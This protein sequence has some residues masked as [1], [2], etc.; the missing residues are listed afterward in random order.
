ML[1]ALRHRNFRLFFYGQSISL[2]GT[3]MQNIALSWLVYRM[4]DSVFLLGIVGFS[5]QIAGFV[6]TPFAGVIADRHHRQKLLI[7]TQFAAMLQA[8]VLTILVAT[9]QIQVWHIILL[10]LLMGAIN[11]FDLPVRQA[12]ISDMIDDREDLSNAIAINSSMVNGARLIGPSIGGILIAMV[13]EV[14]CFAINA[15]SYIAV[16]ISLYN[17]QVAKK[18]ESKRLPLWKEFKEGVFYTFNFMPIRTILILL[19]YSSLVAGG[20]QVLMPVFAREVFLGGA[21]TLGL[22]MA[23][24]GL[25]ALLGAIYLARRKSILGLGKVIA[26]S[27]ALFGAALI[28]F[29]VVPWLW[30][31]MGLLLLSGFGMMVQM[32]ASN[33]V[34]QTLVEED[35]RGRVM[36]FYTMALM[37]VA[38]FGSLLFGSFAHRFGASFVLLLGGGSA[39][40][41]AVL[42]AFCLPRLRELARPVYIQKGILNQIVQ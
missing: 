27:T 7:A 15:I 22:L 38:P 5:S 12:F 35:K 31:S 41:G 8:T 23:S 2:T 10:S 37:G 28:G 25:G 42:F 24:I 11:A 13:G 29:A 36:S 9:H 30:M 40:A 32:A 20:T 3:W 18:A 6:L 39:I 1:R 16:I 14:F 26:A 19:A 34:L 4:T 33:T 17:M 21:Q